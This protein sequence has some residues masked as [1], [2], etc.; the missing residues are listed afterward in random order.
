MIVVTGTIEFAEQDAE[1]AIPLILEAVRLTNEEEGCLFYRFYQDLEI[2]GLFRFYEEWTTM[3][4]LSAHAKS[5]HMAAFQKSRGELT[6]LA[7]AGKI[8]EAQ[9]LRDL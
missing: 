4:A 7:R 1:A 5:A 6:V 3:D 2:R 8:M 9:H